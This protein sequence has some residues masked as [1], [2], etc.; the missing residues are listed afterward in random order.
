MDNK[1]RFLRRR[2]DYRGFVMYG[3]NVRSCSVSDASEG[4]A[5]IQI[6]DPTDVPDRFVL[7][8]SRRGPPCRKCQVVWRTDAALGVRW[9]SQG[10]NNVCDPNVCDADC[11]RLNAS[12]PTPAA[13]TNVWVV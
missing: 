9:E 5:R 6:Q 13:D 3:A 11:P 8:L 4:G 2:L 7:S 12:D 10:H 1:R